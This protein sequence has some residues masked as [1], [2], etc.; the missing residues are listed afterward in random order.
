[1]WKYYLLTD[2][3]NN[4]VIIK[5][6]GRNQ[7][8]YSF[9]ENKWIESGLLIL[10]HT[11]GN[12]FYEKYCELQESEVSKQHEKMDKIYN[13]INTDL[14][15]KAN[16][17]NIKINFSFENLE[18]NIIYLSWIL[19][20]KIVDVIELDHEIGNQHVSIAVNK[21]RENIDFL[22]EKCIREL[23]KDIYTNKITKKIIDQY[24]NENDREIDY[25]I[26]QLDILNYKIY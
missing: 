13:K 12:P 5:A 22:D 3:I 23:R 14:I 6:Q 21:L 16:E 20:E 25:W 11:E 1:M 4:G 2:K 7:Y 8:Q 24:I 18:T 19:S 15:K 26:R 10:Y 17:H 9:G